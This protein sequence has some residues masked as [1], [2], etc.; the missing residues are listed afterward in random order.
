M[1][2]TTDV[3][4][5]GA[6]VIG[7][8]IAYQLSKAKVKTII[9]EK[10]EQ[11]GTEASWASAGMLSI[12]SLADNPFAT[13]AKS[14][15]D[16]YEHLPQELKELTQIDVECL[17]SGAI[18]LM[19]SE[20]DERSARGYYQ[21]QKAQGLEVEF[22]SP[23]E[24]WKLEPAIS[25]EIRGAFLYPRDLQ[26]RN[27][28]FVV[29]LA[30]GASLLGAEILTANPIVDFIKEGE[31]LIGV[32]TPNQTIHCGH[33]VIAAGCWSN[34]VGTLLGLEIP[35]GPA[36][37]QM[38]LAES[39]PHL[40]QHMIHGEDIYLVPRTDGKILIGATVEFVGYDKRVTVGGILSLIEKGVKICPPLQDK[41]VVKTW[42]GLRPHSK[43]PLIG[44]IP[45]IERAI[46]A[47][48][49]FRNGI[50]LSPITGKLVKELI[51]GEKPSVPLDEFQIK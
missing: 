18:E 1:A 17:N 3:L 44:F 21:R 12:R 36:K 32:K 14:S 39:M 50:L 23:E 26:V 24:V 15:F 29:A 28:R 48:G 40:I 7:C 4:I 13:L 33:V 51:L 25:K 34:Q 5:I 46:I 11:V 41:A 47:S 16:M 37:G 22:L 38:V 49:H 35:I 6:G 10:A 42:A 19:F 20:E 31:R 27:P 45:Q 9:V 2:K 8:S 43:H 30:K